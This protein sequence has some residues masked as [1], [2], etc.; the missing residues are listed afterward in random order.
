MPE[1]G[2]KRR[3]DKRRR[4]KEGEEEGWQEEDQVTR[5]VNR[6]LWSKSGRGD[7]RTHNEVHT[8]STNLYQY[9]PGPEFSPPGGVSPS[10]DRRLVTGTE[11]E[12]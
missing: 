11:V 9:T 7:G 8:V 6:Q 2:V 4:K 1:P 12:P 5:Y 3:D 10:V